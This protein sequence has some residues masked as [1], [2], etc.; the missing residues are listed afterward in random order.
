MADMIVAMRFE[1]DP[2][3]ERENR[4]KHGLSF[5]QVT[6]LFTGGR[7]YL[8]LLDEDSSVDEERIIAIGPVG[9]AIVVVVFTERNDQINRIISARPATRSEVHLFHEHMENFR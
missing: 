2:A 3:K 4:S 7:D 1:W 8:E 6:E 9:T 5:G